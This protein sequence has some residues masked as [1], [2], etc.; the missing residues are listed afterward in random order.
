MKASEFLAKWFGI[1][2][3]ELRAFLQNV[4]ATGGDAATLA[5]I[6][7]GKIDAEIDPAHIV[8]AI[9]ALPSEVLDILHTRFKGMKHPSDLIG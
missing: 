6:L 9:A 1:S 7:L 5:G 2:A 4:A 3:D 8:A